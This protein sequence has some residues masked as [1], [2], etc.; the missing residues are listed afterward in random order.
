MSLI[1][2][3]RAKYLFKELRIMAKFEIAHKKTSINE[4]GYTSVR[5]DSGNWTGGVVGVG[6]L[7]GTN[8]GI[9]AP[10]LCEFLRKTATIEDMK[11]ITKDTV[12]IIYRK[13]YWNKIHGD[14]L[15]NQEIANSLYDSAVNMGVGQA[16]K[17]A[18]KALNIPVTGKIDSYMINLLNNTKISL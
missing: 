11:N 13:N 17:L 18:Q 10:V 8:F 7:I 15:T 3:R 12:E 5:E 2:N 14:E 6:K 16:I 9:S 1:T 4:G